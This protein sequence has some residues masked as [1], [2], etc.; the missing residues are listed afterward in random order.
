MSNI[1]KRYT[2]AEVFEWWKIEDVNYFFFGNK[3]RQKQQNVQLF[4]WLFLH[5]GY[6]YGHEFW[7]VFR[8]HCEASKKYN[9]EIFLRI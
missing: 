8:D 4:N 6:T 9:F 2:L 7:R 3:R 5:N 1:Q